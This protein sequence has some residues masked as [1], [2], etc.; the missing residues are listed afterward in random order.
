MCMNCVTICIFSICL[1]YTRLIFLALHFR[2]GKATA[3][4]FFPRP[5]RACRVAAS[6]TCPSSFSSFN[7]ERVV[8]LL[9]IVFNVVHKRDASLAMYGTHTRTHTRTHTHVIQRTAMPYSLPS[10]R[11]SLISLREISRIDNF[12]FAKPHPESVWLPRQYI[13]SF[14]CR[15]KSNYRKLGFTHHR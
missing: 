3:T 10:P 2:G 13:R 14:S 12:F 1:C 15:A 9:C 8:P 5:T 11:V 7:P 6:A 4:A